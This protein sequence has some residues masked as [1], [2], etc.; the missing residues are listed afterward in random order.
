MNKEHHWELEIEDGKIKNRECSQREFKQEYSSDSLFKY[1]KT[2]VGFANHQGGTI[3]FGI[4]DKPKTIVGVAANQIDEADITR[5]LN[6][7]FDP[8]VKYRIEETALN[9]KNILK[10]RDI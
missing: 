5:S 8:E 9:G 4:Q 10:I 7:H 3:F 6:D 2:M 1:I